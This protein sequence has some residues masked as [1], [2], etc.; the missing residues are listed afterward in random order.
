MPDQ[1]T[2]VEE[3]ASFD[4]VRRLTTLR[5]SGVLG[6]VRL[7]AVVL[8]MISAIPAAA[9]EAVA[10]PIEEVVA[11]V[12]TRTI[13][14]SEVDLLVRLE[15]GRKEGQKGLRKAVTA[16]DLAAQLDNLIDRIVLQNEAGRLQSADVAESDITAAFGRLR[17]QIGVA[18]FDR[19]LDEFQVDER[20]I[21]DI[22]KRDLRCQS[23]LEFRFRLSS[24]PRDNELRAFYDSHPD[25]FGTRT[26][27]E[28]VDGLRA[29]I[30]AL[31]FEELTKAFVADVRRRTLVRVLRDFTSATGGTA[32]SGKASAATAAGAAAGPARKPGG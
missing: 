7:A 25:E 26:Y 32:L 27:A 21:R 17:Q 23:Y 1:E 14:L 8:A 30:S 18:A 12:D 13:L 29:R 24:K 2:L 16:E 3:R 11:V 22:V 6:L 9:E 20:T 4:F 10:V 15:R 5:M 31:R 19:F 28:V